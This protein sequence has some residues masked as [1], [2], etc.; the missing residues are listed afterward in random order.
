[1][2]A[3][4]MTKST[5]AAARPDALL[6]LTNDAAVRAMLKLTPD[7]LLMLMAMIRHVTEHDT[8]F[9]CLGDAVFGAGLSRQQGQHGLDDL[10][11]HGLMVMGPTGDFVLHRVFGS[12]GH[13]LRN[14]RTNLDA[15]NNH[16]SAHNGGGIVLRMTT[17]GAG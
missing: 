16:G 9:A 14:L 7:G 4:M 13:G 2:T 8:K 10:K 3:T 12:V 5:K 1:V 11:S 17:A 15:D 6:E